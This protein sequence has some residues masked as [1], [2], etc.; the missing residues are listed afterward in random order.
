MLHIFKISAKIKLIILSLLTLSSSS[1][2]T[3]GEWMKEVLGGEYP[4][5]VAIA[6]AK[7]GKYGVID[8]ELYRQKVN[9]VTQI[10]EYAQTHVLPKNE[11]LNIYLLKRGLLT[12]QQ[13]QS[14]FWETIN[15]SDVRTN[16]TK[17][18]ELSAMHALYEFGPQNNEEWKT[19]FADAEKKYPSLY[20]E[21]EAL[22]GLKAILETARISISSMPPCPDEVSSSYLNELSLHTR[23]MN[24]VMGFL[25]D[26]SPEINAMIR[27]FQNL[28]KF[29]IKKQ[30]DLLEIDDSGF[31][32]NVSCILAVVDIDYKDRDQTL[33]SPSIAIT[34]IND[35]PP[36]TPWEDDTPLSLVSSWPHGNF[37][38]T[39]TENFVTSSHHA[40]YYPGLPDKYCPFT[41]LKKWYKEPVV[42]S[43]SFHPL[44]LYPFLKKDDSGQITFN[45]SS[46]LEIKS[47]GN[48]AYW[49]KL[50]TERYPSKSVDGPLDEEQLIYLKSEEEKNR[51]SREASERLAEVVEDETNRR[52]IVVVAPLNEV[53]ALQRTPD[54]YSSGRIKFLDDPRA[55]EHAIV[56][57][58]YNSL[59]DRLESCSAGEFQEIALVVPSA[60]MAVVGKEN[61]LPYIRAGGNSAATAITSA[62]VN[63][64]QMQYPDLTYK[65][66]KQALFEGANKTFTG[67]DPSLHGQGMLNLRG[68][69]EVATR[70]DQSRCAGVQ[71]A[72]TSS[73]S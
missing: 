38:F 72:V 16:Y 67:Y 61:P 25:T 17:A 45:S 49:K 44:C 71:T 11:N 43:L 29:W 3:R 10:Y 70:L 46:Q 6:K 42:Y 63:R 69:L 66:L 52:Q 18:L 22:K 8:N 19:V 32:H 51:A 58:N 23:A 55:Y 33:G 50:L 5:A 62:V 4:I 15:A 14:H 21:H 73:S 13:E 39:I 65:E 56:A 37:M 24:Y 31:T 35:I 20:V 12:F 7:E 28:Q 41:I 57:L 27:D 59:E 68:A 47:P 48:I 64:V 9:E 26:M 53:G 40:Y 34:G 2:A 60:Q 1:Y 54:A 36:K 30:K